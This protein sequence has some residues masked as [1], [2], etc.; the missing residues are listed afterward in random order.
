MLTRGLKR[1]QPLPTFDP[2]AN[3]TPAKFF[4]TLSTK[5][6]TSGMAETSRK[7]RQRNIFR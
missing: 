4:E 1:F 7:A 6:N 3:V 2:G 5:T